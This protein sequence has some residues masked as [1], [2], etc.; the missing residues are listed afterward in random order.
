M[1][2]AVFGSGLR[3]DFGAESDLDVLVEFAPDRVP[4]WEYVRIADELSRL[5][6][7][8]VDMLTFGGIR[9]AYRSRILSTARTI[10]AAA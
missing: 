6:G 8:R 10:Y 7:R 5:V 1:R 2:L 3:E 4:G 9:P